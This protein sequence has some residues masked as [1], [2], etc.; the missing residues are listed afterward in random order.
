M[1]ANFPTSLDTDTTVGGN[2]ADN[3]ASTDATTTPSHSELHQDVGDAVQAVE[4]KLGTGSSTAAANQ[5][6]TGSGSGTS[7]WAAITN[8]MVN[9]T[10]TTY[11][12]EVYQRPNT[13]NTNEVSTS[14]NSCLYFELGTLC[15][16]WGYLAFTPGAEVTSGSDIYMR[17]PRGFASSSSYCFGTYSFGDSSGGGY[18]NG[19]VIGAGVTHDVVTFAVPDASIQ[20][21]AADNLGDKVDIASGDTL[22]FGFVFYT[23]QGDPATT[24]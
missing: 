22:S 20:L 7:E 13:W 21:Y 15:L 16:C 8:A 4:A 11:T 1:A 9:F 10:G 2:T 17:T 24:G 12:A 14:T 18:Y 5:V 19:M 3:P 23:A 6:L